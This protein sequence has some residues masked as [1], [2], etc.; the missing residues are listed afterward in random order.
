MSQSEKVDLLSKALVA[1]QSAC[2]NVE[3]KQTGQQGNRKF[4]Y[5][6]L[7]AVLDEIK[8]KLADAKLAIL[9]MPVSDDS[10]IGVVT[11]IVHESGQYI[12]L[13]PL[14]LPGG[15]STQDGGKA[16]TYAQRYVV[17]AVA[18]IAT[19]EDTEGP[20]G[21]N[22]GSRGRGRSRAQ[23]P[24]S[25]DAP[26]PSGDPPPADPPP[27]DPPASTGSAEVGAFDKK[28]GFGRHA[29]LTWR[30]LCEGSIG[31]ER[32]TYVGHM[33]GYLNPEESEET[34]LMHERFM[35]C[36]RIYGGKQREKEDADGEGF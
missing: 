12:E 1:F 28:L 8:P 30:Q 16:I 6:D 17:R 20:Q 5:A 26:S 3:P 11:R 31:G 24:S 21:G 14:L 10:G 36:L 15:Q 18:L 33:V 32:H 27:S 9:Q 23:G 2:S 4:K 19:D 34:K 7:A 22:G 29:D 25:G 35:K 13:P